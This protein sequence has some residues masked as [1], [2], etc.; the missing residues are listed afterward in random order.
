MEKVIQVQELT[1]SYGDLQVL[2]GVN[3][4]AQRGEIVSVMGDSG[5]GKTTFLQILGTLD[6]ADGG[7]LNL[8]GQEVTKLSDKKLAKFRNQEI[9]FI[10]QFHHLLPE[11][12]ALENT[13]IPGLIAKRK[14][15]ELEE[16][17]KELLD[18]LGLGNRLNHKPSQM[19]GGEQ[20][21]VA[22]ARALM[23]DPS[24]L[25]ADEPTGNLDSRNA[26]ELHKMFY[27]LRDR[28]N[29]TIVIIT[30]NPDLAKMSDRQL[31]MSDGVLDS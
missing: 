1:K 21:R 13:F 9:G 17:A 19:S 8:N 20:Q 14:K 2:K 11:F 22:V 24:I 23:N 28:F 27:S 30:H 16:K 6:K 31:H 4:E 26:E 25:L 29:S 7:S 5:A 3:F 10:F 15:S 18:F 12:T